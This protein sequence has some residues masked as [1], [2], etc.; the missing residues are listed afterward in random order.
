M[1]A[2]AAG[3]SVLACFL[4]SKELVV[5]LEAPVAAQVRFDRRML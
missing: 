5:F 2:L 3:T 4:F 1:G